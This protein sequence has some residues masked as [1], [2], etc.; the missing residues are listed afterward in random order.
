MLH[1]FCYLSNTS[2]SLAYLACLLSYFAYNCVQMTPWSFFF[3]DSNGISL[4][5]LVVCCLTT[6]FFAKA[7]KWY[8]FPYYV[9]GIPIIKANAYLGYSAATKGK[10]DAHV[11]LL[12][13]ANK[14]GKM[15]QF[16][17]LG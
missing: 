3:H 4:P 2:E 11:N 9:P 16:Y 13:D 1:T 15:F 12:K 17:F 8:F 5:L 14:L 7:I 6:Y 10:F